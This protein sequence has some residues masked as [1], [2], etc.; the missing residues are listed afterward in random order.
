MPTRA[1]RSSAGT[2][3]GLNGPVTVGADV[4]GLPSGAKPD[5]VLRIGGHEFHSRVP[6]VRL[7]PRQMLAAAGFPLV[8]TTEQTIQLTFEVRSA[9]HVLASAQQSLAFGPTDGTY[10]E[11][12]A[13][14]APAT[15]QP[16][17]PVTVHYDLT[18]VQNVSSPQLIVSA[19]G[20]WSPAA[21]PL[22]TAA[23]TVPLTSLTGNVTIPA[24]A[25]DGGGGIYGIGLVTRHNGTPAG[26][27]IPVYGE[28]APIRVTGGTPAQRPAAPTLAAAG[29]DHFGH[30]AEILTR[31]P[32]FKLRYDV[33][34][35]P[36]AAG[37]IFEVSAP[38]APTVRKSLN[39][40]T[41][42]NGTVRDHDGVDTGSVVYQRLPSSSGTVAFN[43]V[44][45]GLAGSLH[46]NIRV[47]PTDRNGKVIGQ[48]S[49]TSMLTLD[50]GLA[51]DGGLVASFAIQPGGI[52]AASVF[53]PATGGESLREYNA[54]T[55]AYGKT[56][57]ADPP[58]LYQSA[59]QIIG[60][61]PGV[62]RLLVRTG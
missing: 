33:R 2:A 51:P 1:W 30:A 8:S 59:Y 14:V 6:A 32:G 50:D 34:T 48:A 23:Y 53:D 36:G 17:R 40:V 24:T 16:G 62:H 13:P 55:G 29:S 49:A 35:V 19:V 38:A 43:A 37:A 61:D 58:T 54:S 3:E 4:T 45:L 11:A 25:F 31:T 39:T 28:F 22:V 15:V 26:T 10:L 20:H 47:F 46:Y 56:L 12:M 57:A 41:N 21:A 60:I 9:G 7:T 5:Y 52:S 42:A 18:G 27:T 44:K